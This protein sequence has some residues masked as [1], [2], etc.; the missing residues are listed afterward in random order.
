MSTGRRAA[1]VYLVHEFWIRHQNSQVDIN[2]CQQTALQL[3][4]PKLHGVGVMELQDQTVNGNVVHPQGFRRYSLT[5]LKLRPR[6][7]SSVV[8]CGEEPQE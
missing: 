8:T 4:L 1:R 2:R 6:N 3:V 7:R 5:S